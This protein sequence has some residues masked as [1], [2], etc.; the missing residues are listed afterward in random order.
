MPLATQLT[1]W[2]GQTKSELFVSPLNRS[3][4]RLKV[5]ELK[6][7]SHGFGGS[8]LSCLLPERRRGKKQNQK[9]VRSLGRHQGDGEAGAGVVHHG[10]QLALPG[11]D[12]LRRRHGGIALE[13]ACGRIGGIARGVKNDRGAG[14][15]ALGEGSWVWDPIPFA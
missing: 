6:E 2:T 11:E 14:S 7:L 10:R 8:S 3:F 9:N 15:I 4:N 5:H 13:D 1:E 12:G